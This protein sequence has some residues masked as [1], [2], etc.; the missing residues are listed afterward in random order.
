M[1][2][3]SAKTWFRNN[4]QPYLEIIKLNS[5]GNAP[6][7]DSFSPQEIP[8]GSTMIIT[9]TGQ[10][11]TPATTFSSPSGTVSNIV[12]ISTH[13][14]T[15]DLIEPSPSLVT[16]TVDNGFSSTTFQ[17]NAI[18]APWVDC[19]LGSGSI[20][21]VQTDVFG[22]GMIR[23]ARGVGV[24][25]SKWDAFVKFTSHE[26][27]RS[28]PAKVTIIMETIGNSNY[29]GIFGS[30]QDTLS[31]SQEDEFEIS[32]FIRA[33]DNLRRFRG[34]DVNHIALSSNIPQ[35]TVTSPY[36]K[37]VFFNNGAGGNAFQAFEK[38]DLVDFD[39]NNALIVTEGIPA[40]F[41]ADSPLLQVGFSGNSNARIV[42]FRIEN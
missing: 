26:W 15:F 38:D 1:A 39:V 23:D 14:M 6:I 32:M 31:N 2:I 5:S 4:I 9:V 36:Y 41:T 29:A 24:D 3:F 27:S 11:L 22:N 20:F 30:E 28:N 40:T 12:F 42:A 33:N 7:I 13:E 10:F 35:V 19:R 8:T 21:T 18:V 37:I 34:T 17:I 25:S 16:I